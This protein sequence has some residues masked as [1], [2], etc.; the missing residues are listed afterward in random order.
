MPQVLALHCLRGTRDY[1]YQ[2]AFAAAAA[3]AAAKRFS[4]RALCSR[5][6]SHVPY[7]ARKTT[8]TMSAGMHQSNLCRGGGP[9][10][11]IPLAIGP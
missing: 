3:G 10:I 6:A 8:P 7:S 9:Q 1:R 2:S 4:W 11:S 5:H